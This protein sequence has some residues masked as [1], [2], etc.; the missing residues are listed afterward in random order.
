MSPVFGH[1]FSTTDNELFTPPE[2]LLKAIKRITVTITPI[3]AKLLFQFSI[4]E[5][6]VTHNI[7]FLINCN[8]NFTKLVED[9]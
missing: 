4:N 3:P 7:N 8:Y 1:P 6:S 2:W 5:N 9:N